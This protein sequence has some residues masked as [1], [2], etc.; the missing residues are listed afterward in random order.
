MPTFTPTKQIFL[1]SHILSHWYQFEAQLLGKNIWK[2]IG[3]LL[4]ELLAI[5]ICFYKSKLLVIR[6]SLHTIRRT[7]SPPQSHLGLR[8]YSSSNDRWAFIC[9]FVRQY[10]KFCL[11]AMANI[12][13]T[14]FDQLG[15]ICSDYPE[16]YW[17]ITIWAFSYRLIAGKYISIL[18]WNPH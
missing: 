7:R 14:H 16:E 12:T 5:S 3:M 11:V 1:D 18:F 15:T 9:D 8:K 10:S 4:A 2:K 6:F 17:C 13:I